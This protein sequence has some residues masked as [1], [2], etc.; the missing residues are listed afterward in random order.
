MEI[1]YGDKWVIFEKG[2]FLKKRTFREDIFREM[3]VWGRSVVIFIQHGGG[4]SEGVLPPMPS[5]QPNK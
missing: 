3:H 4:V 5:P 2:R 1:F